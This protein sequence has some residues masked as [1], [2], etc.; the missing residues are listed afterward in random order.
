MREIMTQYC[1]NRIA[2]FL[3]I[4]IDEAHARDEWWLPDSPEAKDGERR[5][6]YSPKTVEERITAAKKMK[7][8]LDFPGEIICDSMNGEVEDRFEAWPERVYIILNGV[9]VYKGGEGPFFYKLSEVQDWL[10]KYHPNE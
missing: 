7:T 8:D 4:Y 2:R 1:D 6:I 3:T 10:A 9:V 5:C